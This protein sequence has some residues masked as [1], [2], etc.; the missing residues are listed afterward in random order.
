M[1]EFSISL[2]RAKGKRILDKVEGF[3]TVVGIESHIIG[4][5]GGKGNCIVHGRVEGDCNIEGALVIGN[6]G[7]WVGNIVAGCV[8]IAG[9]VDGNVTA[10]EKMEIVS[11]ARVNGKITS[12][13]LA[14]A[15]GAIHEGEIQISGAN[16][17]TR[18]KDRRSQEG[19]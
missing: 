8:L 18:F 4:V 5:I 14:I 13:V 16:T 19:K 6:G 10:N 7:H 9:T 17:I 3:T 2:G 15:E 11:T 12:N 1:K